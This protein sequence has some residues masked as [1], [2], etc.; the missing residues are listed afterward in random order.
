M[1]K[2][3]LLVLLLAVVGLVVVIA[4]R[5]D[6]LHIERSATVGAPPQFVHG[7]I[8]D[9][10][11]WGEWSP[12]EK[13]DPMMKKDFEGGPGAGAKYHWS[14]N[15][16][17]GEGKMSITSSAPDKIVIALEFIKPWTATSTATFTFA[18]EGAGTKVVWSSDGKQSFGAK[19]YGLMKNMDQMI[20]KDYE[21]GLA[22]MTAPAAADAQKAAAAEAAAKAAAAAEAAKKAAEA[23]AAA[24]P[25]APAKGA[26]PAKGGKKHK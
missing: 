6:T 25:P 12:W 8:N 2:K 13:L 9:F 18:P 19:A 26:K 22:G 10:H 4:T 16:K 5:P 14:G 17:V 21:A 15:D 24:A 3:I 23:A 7:I 11:R 1:A 20:G